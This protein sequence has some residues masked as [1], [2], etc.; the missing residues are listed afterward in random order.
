MNFFLKQHHTGSRSY[1]VNGLLND[2]RPF[3]ETF[4][5]M[6]NPTTWTQ[7]QTLSGFLLDRE[8][9]RRR[10]RVTKEEESPHTPTHTTTNS[11]NDD[12]VLTA[13]SRPNSTFKTEGL[14]AYDFLNLT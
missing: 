13:R 6:T 2:E 8:E 5:Q 12:D 7:Y 10:E 14:F 9:K 3:L 4:E 11:N 1:H